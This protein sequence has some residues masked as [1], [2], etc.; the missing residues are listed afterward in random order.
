MKLVMAQDSGETIKKIIYKFD[1]ITK[2]LTDKNCLPNF[3]ITKITPE[4]QT[5]KSN[6]ELGKLDIEITCGINQETITVKIIKT[7]SGWK[8][9]EKLKLIYRE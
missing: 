4:K 3:T 2:K 7:K 6:I 8:I 1:E 5:L 9:L